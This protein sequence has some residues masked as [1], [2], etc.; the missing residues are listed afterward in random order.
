[1]ELFKNGLNVYEYEDWYNGQSI[2]LSIDSS[3]SNTAMIVWG[4]DWIALDAYEI[5][6][7]GGDVDVY[8]LCWDTRNALD[9]LFHGAKVMLVGI[10][11][12][13]TK[14]KDNKF[15]GLNHHESRRKITAVFDNLV[16]YSQDRFG[17]N[18]VKVNNWSWKAGVLPEEYRKDS[19]RKGSWDWLN[20]IGSRWA[21]MK[22]DVTDAYCI[23]LYLKSLNQYNFEVVK[24]V[25]STEPPKYSYDFKIY[26]EAYEVPSI[27]KKFDIKNGDTLQH[28]LDTISNQ[29]DKKQIGCVSVPTEMLPME[30]IYSDK[31]STN[32][33][34]YNR[35]EN[36]CWIVLCRTS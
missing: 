30:L 6:G 24:E 15:T 23:G 2:I 22:D 17:V 20:D 4:T 35:V 18:P 14:A 13:V 9:K 25:R 8:D 29:L 31:L 19:H 28:N 36:N 10:E 7:A 32:G 5:S 11:D 33:M 21:G 12:I 26:P 34:E 16:F 27:C 3:K 1:M